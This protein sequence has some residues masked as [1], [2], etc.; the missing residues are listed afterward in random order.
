MTL[1]SGGCESPDTSV[2]SDVADQAR[3]APGLAIDAAHR[4][5]AAGDGLAS[6]ARDAFVSGMRFSMLVGAVLLVA[7]AAFVALRGPSRRDEFGEDDLDDAEAV[8]DALLETEI[9]V[10]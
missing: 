6:A 8:D 4:L 5:G 9:A 10:A 3:Q 2:P 1:T 7:A